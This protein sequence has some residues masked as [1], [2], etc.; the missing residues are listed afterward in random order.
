M[1]DVTFIKSQGNLN[2]TSPNQDNISG[3][4]FYTTSSLP[5]G[6]SGA[7]NSIQEIFSPVDAVNLGLTSTAYPIE[8]YQISEFFRI[9]P[10]ATLYVTFGTGETFA[11]GYTYSTGSTT[12][13]EIQS[14]Q[15]YSQGTIRQCGVLNYMPFTSGMTDIGALQSIE[16][17]L[18]S[19]SMPLSIVYGSTTKSFTLTGLPSLRTETANKVSMVIGQDGS[20]TGA[21]LATTYGVSVPAVGACLGTISLAKVSENI[22]W[23]N[24]FDI[25]NYANLEY[26]TPAFGNGALVQNQTTALLTQI[27]NNGY[28][29]LRKFI[30]L[31]GT[32]W[33]DSPTAIVATSDYAYIEENRTIDK[34]IRGIRTYVLPF[35]NGPIKIDPTSGKIDI[36]TI[37]VIENAVGLPLTVMVSATEISGFNVFINPNQNVLS[38]S[39]LYIVVKIVPI[40]VAREIVVTIG[41]ALSV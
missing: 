16:T 17:T 34:A 33:N 39:I 38:T 6:F 28:I 15:V 10:N 37:K 24:Q 30:G 32:Y 2:S 29:F 4:V 1:N 12:Y 40:G 26:D 20:A 13:S 21:A 36:T 19:M 7:T 8:N 11:T 22:G 14:L 5:A 41:F 25:K 27:Q 18:E 9:N 31:N 35:L 3:F 23:V